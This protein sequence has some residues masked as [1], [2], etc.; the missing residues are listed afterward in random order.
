VT[1]LP[2]RI[3]EML[4][5]YYKAYRPKVWLFEGHKA[6]HKYSAESLAKV[7]RKALSLAGN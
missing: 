6:G 2:E 5:D 4:R 1:P 7:L 3:V